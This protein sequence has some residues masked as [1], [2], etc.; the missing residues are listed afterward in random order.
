MNINDKIDK[1]LENQN[2]IIDLQQKERVIKINNI[3]SFIIILII[4]YI[5]FEGWN[6]LIL[7]TFNKYYPTNNLKFWERILL[8]ISGTILIIILIY[9]SGIKLQSLE[10]AI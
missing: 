2:N 8:L 4:A 5:V 9:F 6:K 10:T 7:E 1:I 3:I